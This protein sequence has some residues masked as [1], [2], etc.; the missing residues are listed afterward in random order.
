[1][2]AH[3]AD[4]S[5]VSAADFLNAVLGPRIEP[6]PIDWDAVEARRSFV[7]AER[8]AW[9]EAMKLKHGNPLE[10]F[11]QWLE[12]RDSERITDQLERELRRTV[13]INSRRAA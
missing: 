2:T 12:R 13:E 11:A 8:E 3:F 6:T 7:C 10:T 4:A 5:K 9:M 1:M